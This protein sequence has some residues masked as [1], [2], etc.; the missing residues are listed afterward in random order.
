MCHKKLITAG[1]NI[2][3]HSTEIEV[4]K[5][6]SKRYGKLP[7]EYL[8]FIKT[9]KEVI[10]ESNTTWFNLN[11]EFDG[12]PENEF[13][14]NEFELMSLEWS[15]DDTDE[16]EAIT[17]FWKKHFP[18]VMSVKDGY[19]FLAICLETDKYGM[20]VH[21]QEPEFEDVTKICSNFTELI[22]L[23]VNKELEYIF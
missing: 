3:R 11:K 10:N 20:I 4:S 9:F 13:R 16:L 17:Q 1:F 5:S 19:Q 2:K 12:N 22:D 7:A 6:L 14:W 21:G 23:L 8:T 15:E 18:I